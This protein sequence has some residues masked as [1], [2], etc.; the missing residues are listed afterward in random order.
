MGR[1]FLVRDVYLDKE[2]ALKILH[3]PPASAEEMEQFHREFTL[4]SQVEHPAIA[5]AYDLGYLEERPYFT[6]EFVPGDTLARHVPLRDT[7]RFLQVALEIA[8]ALAFLHRSGILH[9]DVK[10]S[11][12]VVPSGGRPDQAVL[13]DFGLCRRG[14][15]TVVEDKL[16]G[17]LP[18][19]APEYFQQGPLGPWTDVYAFGVTLY[20]VATGIFP[21]PGGTAAGASLSD[22]AA[23]VPVPRPPCQLRP[24]LLRDLD[25]VLLRC[26]TLD[27]R[28]RFPSG[29]E[30]LAA[31][32]KTGGVASRPRH[33]L[34]PP[35]ATAG[36]TGELQQAERFL[37]DLRRVE[38]GPAAL[39]VTGLSGMGQSHFLEAVKRRA[40]TLGFDCFLETGYAGKPAVPGSLLRGL[41]TQLASEEDP[42][43]GARWEAFLGRLRRP[44]ASPRLDI[45]RRL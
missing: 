13:I 43:V 31:L 17:S 10:P 27:W 32:E 40:Q 41:S 26:L 9:L 22:E 45:H 3:A 34:P 33:E 19:L 29:G 18:Y 25:H 1:V 28:T 7:D 5:R 8:E 42:G 12:I 4:L 37:R 36:R 14:L 6:T 30:L 16:R 11:N 44:R 21:R 24:S 20:R 15:G 23:W 35:H 39:L 2:L 38:G